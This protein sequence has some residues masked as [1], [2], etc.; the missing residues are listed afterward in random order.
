M[1][2]PH[3]CCLIPGNTNFANLIADIALLKSETEHVETRLV[4]GCGRWPTGVSNANINLAG[5]FQ[6]Q[7]YKLLCLRGIRHINRETR[8]IRASLTRGCF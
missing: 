6:Y 1:I 7:F 2:R 8:H 3:F 4:E 5:P